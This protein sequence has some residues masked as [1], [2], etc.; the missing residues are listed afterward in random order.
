MVF[1]VQERLLLFRRLRLRHSPTL[2]QRHDHPATLLRQKT[3][4]LLLTRHHN[5]SPPAVYG[6]DSDVDLH[7]RDYGVGW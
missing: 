5:S 7:E 3:Q 6:F 4:P 2:R 1:L